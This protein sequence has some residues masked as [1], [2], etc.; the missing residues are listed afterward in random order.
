M[1]TD[2]VNIKMCLFIQLL[3]LLVEEGLRALLFGRIKQFRRGGGYTPNLEKHI[4]LE[5][6]V[7]S[8]NRREKCDAFKVI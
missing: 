1:F 5:K 8:F 3:I 4:L 7:S 2:S 6:G